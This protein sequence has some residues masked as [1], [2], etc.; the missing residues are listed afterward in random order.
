MTKEPTIPA[1]ALAMY[2]V[3]IKTDGSMEN[4]GIGHF[5]VEH[6]EELAGRLVAI[7]S[8]IRALAERRLS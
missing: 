4:I 6:A 3:A 2:G 5:D 7:A 8:S 1:P